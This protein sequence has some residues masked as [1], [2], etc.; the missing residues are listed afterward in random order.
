MHVR[1]SQSPTPMTHDNLDVPMRGLHALRGPSVMRDDMPG[2]DQGRLSDPGLVLSGAHT[3][4]SGSMRM[5]ESHAGRH[6]AAYCV[7]RSVRLRRD[8][9]WQK[10]TQGL[11][12]AAGPARAVRSGPVSGTRWTRNSIRPLRGCPWTAVMQ[13]GRDTGHSEIFLLAPA[14]LP[15]GGQGFAAGCRLFQFAQKIRRGAGFGV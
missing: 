10:L 12:C 14:P 8:P 13:S 1:A 11:S 7:F 15:R 5:M 9:R 3:S 6:G 2:F 4:D